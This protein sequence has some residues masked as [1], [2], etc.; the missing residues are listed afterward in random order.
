MKQYKVLFSPAAL[1][2]LKEAKHWYNTQQKGLGLRLLKDVKEATPAI[3]LNPYHA[4]VKF[5]NIRTT[6]C[7]IFPYAV[8]YEIDEVNNLVRIVSIFHFSRK[9]YWLKDD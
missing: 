1:N 9:P 8:H 7:K 3:K 6:A 4:S 5:E 2:D